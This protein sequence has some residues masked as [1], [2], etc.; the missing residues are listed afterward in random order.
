MENEMVKDSKKILFIGSG[1]IVSELDT[2]TSEHILTHAHAW[3]VDQIHDL[4]FFDLEP[5]H[6][7]KAAQKWDGKS[8]TEDEIPFHTWDVITVATPDDT[9]LA[10]CQKIKDLSYKVIVL[11][12]PPTTSL[13][14]WYQLNEL[15]KLKKASICVHYIR[16]F[17]PL[18]QSIFQDLQNQKW[19][20]LLSIQAYYGNG[21]I[22]NACHIIDLITWWFGP[23]TEFKLHSPIYDRPNDPS[24]SV[25][26][27]NH[28]TNNIL[29]NPISSQY[30]TLFEIDIILSE[31]RIRLTNGGLNIEFYEVKESPVFKGFQTLQLQNCINS[32][33][34]QSLK[35]LQK[36]ILEHINHQIPL[37]A[38]LDSIH[39]GFQT[40]LTALE[41][42]DL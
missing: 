29:I 37:P 3:Y 19:G 36:S 25:I 1:R 11:E 20:Q 15:F 23:F 17:P 9:H 18:F 33:L 14:D 2:P 7:L 40:V 32:E 26:A 12:K 8:F 42:K 16:R 6:S 41:K 13:S 5:A 27:Q 28:L 4:Y 10:W 38:T 22:H 24:F 39:D 30:Y 34:N 31:G 21:F 35:F